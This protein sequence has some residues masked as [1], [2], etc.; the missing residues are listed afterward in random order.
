LRGVAADLPPDRR[1]L[2]CCLWVDGELVASRLALPVGDTLYLYHSGFSPAWWWY[3]VS[4]TLTAEC[5]KWAINAGF[6]DVNLSTGWDYAKTR[7]RPDERNLTE[8]RMV[9]PSARARLY[10]N[11]AVIAL[12]AAALANHAASAVVARL[13]LTPGQPQHDR[14][15]RR[16][17]AL[18]HASR[19]PVS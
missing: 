17:H 1:M 7:W 18:E 19:S 4:T 9:A 3:G 10:V 14:R 16:A 15:D 2:V 5:L 13:P 6:R 8:W 12:R 11:S